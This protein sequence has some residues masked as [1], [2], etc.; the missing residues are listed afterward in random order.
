MMRLVIIFLLMSSSLTFAGE[1]MQSEFNN[2]QDKVSYSVGVDVGS[3][4]K[5]QAIDIDIELLL[6]GIKDAISGQLLLTD[7][8]RQTVMTNFQKTQAELFQ[9]MGE[10]SRVEGEKFLEENKK[11][12]GVVE[13]KSG[14]QYKVLKEGK[15]NKPNQSD[16]IEIHYKGMFLDGTVFDNSYQR[17]KPAEYP[18]S[19][20]IYGMQQA[21]LLMSVNSKWQIFV[22]PSLA[23]GP[24]GVPP[25][26]PPYSTLIFEVD[27]FS[28]KKPISE[29]SKK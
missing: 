14:L 3:R 15:G 13:L 10:K 2:E 29:E 22:P 21:L 26:I 11:K 24:R 19:N 4:L 18:I 16:I 25:L 20:M 1:E 17:E 28:I 7:E 27:L 8:E 5:S 12:E 23:Y 9:S 6:K